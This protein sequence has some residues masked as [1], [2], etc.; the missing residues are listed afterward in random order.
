MHFRGGSRMKFMNAIASLAVVGAFMPVTIPRAVA[1]SQAPELCLAPVNDAVAA[2]A[3]G[4]DVVRPE[5]SIQLSAYP[6]WLS[7]SGNALWT[8]GPDN[9]RQVL[10]ISWQHAG[11]LQ[12]VIDQINPCGEFGQRV[13]PAVRLRPSQRGDGMCLWSLFWCRAPES[14]R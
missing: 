7:T 5:D 11:K 1:Q 2:S 4:I 13:P 8:F 9:V 12:A 14:T 3:R 10:A 6:H